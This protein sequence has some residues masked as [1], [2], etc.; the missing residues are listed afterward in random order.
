MAKENIIPDITALI[1]SG[2]DFNCI[3]EGI[4]PYIYYPKITQN[5]SGASVNEL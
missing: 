5:L 1:D 4:I 3:R 2:A